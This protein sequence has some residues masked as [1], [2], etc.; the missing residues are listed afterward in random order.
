MS[1]TV[2]L[3]VEEDGSDPDWLAGM[4]SDQHTPTYISLDHFETF[5][6][7]MKWALEI[8]Q[9]ETEGEYEVLDR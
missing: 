6:E 4:A 2:F 1:T 9:R 7:A 3:F 8:A 5:D